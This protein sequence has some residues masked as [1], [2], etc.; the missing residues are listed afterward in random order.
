MYQNRGNRQSFEK[1]IQEKLYHK[2]N[3][4]TIKTETMQEAQKIDIK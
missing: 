1:S 4:N 2:I 3:K